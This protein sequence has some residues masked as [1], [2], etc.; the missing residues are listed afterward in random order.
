MLSYYEYQG[1]K[2]EYKFVVNGT[3]VF[4]RGGY[5]VGVGVYSSPTITHRAS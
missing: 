4:S 5:C 1:S 2:Y 3:S